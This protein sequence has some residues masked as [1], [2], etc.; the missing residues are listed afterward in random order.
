MASVAFSTPTKKVPKQVPKTPGTPRNRH[1]WIQENLYDRCQIKPGKE[2]LGVTKFAEQL[3]ATSTTEEVLEL[4]P[5]LPSDINKKQFAEKWKSRK[6]CLNEYNE[7]S[8]T[9]TESLK[10][11]IEE[12]KKE[13]AKQK[14]QFHA[15]T[16]AREERKKK[17]AKMAASAAQRKHEKEMRQAE[18]KH[19]KEMRA[20]EQTHKKEMGKMVID[21]LD[22]NN[23]REIDLSK[24]EEETRQKE[25]ETRVQK[26]NKRVEE[27][28]QTIKAFFFPTV[29]EAAAAAPTETG[30]DAD[31]VAPTGTGTGTG[32]DT[33]IAPAGKGLDATV[34]APIG[35]GLDAVAKDTPT[36]GC[37]CK[38]ICCLVVGFVLVAII[39]ACF[40]ITCVAYANRLHSTGA[41]CLP[42]GLDAVPGD[43]IEVYV[44]ADAMANV[45][46]G[47]IVPATKDDPKVPAST[48]R[49]DDL[50]SIVTLALMEKIEHYIDT[51]AISDSTE[52]L[53]NWLYTVFASVKERTVSYIDTITTPRIDSTAVST[54]AVT[55]TVTHDPG[56]AV[57]GKRPHR[58][59]EDPEKDAEKVEDKEL[60]ASEHSD[61]RGPSGF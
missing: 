52:R 1:F 7:R 60:K 40:A 25:E 2:V 29:T 26:A 54:A 8:E 17:E 56:P 31:V 24:K 30:H 34:I 49:C 35:T 13:D 43:V 58:R 15:A 37:N 32:L 53:G 27:T 48:E 23:E 28:S 39:S 42:S 51:K 22:R 21:A 18:Q 4:L 57:E 47:D 19:E 16:S 10:I 11:V 20:S 46:P 12:R 50:F 55:V 3:L 5:P 61:K 45:V 59:T 9:S 38:S 36:A 33:V 14:A 6:R 44:P 41:V